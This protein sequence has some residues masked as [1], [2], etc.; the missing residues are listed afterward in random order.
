MIFEA[1]SRILNSSSL[2]KDNFSEQFKID[3]VNKI[4]SVCIAPENVLDFSVYTDDVD[5]ST[6]VC[7]I[8]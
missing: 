7:F 4:K 3:L 5:N 1:H 6:A 2:F 8:E